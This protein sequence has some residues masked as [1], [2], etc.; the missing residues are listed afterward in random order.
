MKPSTEVRSTK[1]EVRNKTK[2]EE[3]VFSLFG[4]RFYA[5]TPV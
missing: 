3:C 2:K 4:L 5:E 1:S